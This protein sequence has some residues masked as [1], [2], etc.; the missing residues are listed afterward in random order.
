MLVGMGVRRFWGR[1]KIVTMRVMGIVQMFMP[2]QGGL[3][4]R[5]GRFLGG[6]F[7]RVFGDSFAAGEAKDQRRQHQQRD[8]RRSQTA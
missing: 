6:I 3:L 5:A 7:G 4:R 2:S 8:N 1:L